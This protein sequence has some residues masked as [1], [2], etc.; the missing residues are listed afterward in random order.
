MAQELL[1]TY[2]LTRVGAHPE[3]GPGRKAGL[4]TQPAQGA[5]SHQDLSAVSGSG[6]PPPEGRDSNFPASCSAE[7][8]LHLTEDGW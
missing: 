2:Q 5:V 8:N 4:G 1:L 6:P 7:T 3:S